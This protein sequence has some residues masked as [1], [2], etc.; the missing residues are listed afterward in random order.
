VILHG[1]LSSKFY[2]TSKFLFGVAIEIKSETQKFRDPDL[3]RAA[4]HKAELEVTLL[5]MG[6]A[7][8]GVSMY[9]LACVLV[10]KQA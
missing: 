10:R 7:Q 3:T 2:A 4:V 8:K 6:Q 1:S 5:A 9:F